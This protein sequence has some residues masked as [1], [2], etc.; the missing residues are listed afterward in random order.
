MP[1]S[2]EFAEMVRINREMFFDS[3]EHSAAR[4]LI[5]SLLD[6]QTPG[7]SGGRDLDGDL[8]LIESDPNQLTLIGRDILRSALAHFICAD[9]HPKYWYGSGT[10]LADGP[11]WTVAGYLGR[12]EVGT[13]I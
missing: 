9:S 4:S 8:R 2:P 13:E 6:Y 3:G 7:T 12:T 10:E 1:S 5:R 11:G